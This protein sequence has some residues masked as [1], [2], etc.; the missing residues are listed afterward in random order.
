[1]GWDFDGCGLMIQGTFGWILQD[2]GKYWMRWYFRI[3]AKSM[4]QDTG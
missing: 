3:L 2:T 1:L 4:L